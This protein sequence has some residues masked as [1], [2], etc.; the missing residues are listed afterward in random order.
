MIDYLNNIYNNEIPFAKLIKKLGNKI[1]MDDLN[2]YQEFNQMSIKN[3]NIFIDTVNNKNGQ[4]EIIQHGSSIHNNL[5][6]KY[7]EYSR[8]KKEYKRL[9][10]NS[11]Q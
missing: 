4:F 1:T 10:I 11:I 2:I 9:K 6:N 8:L 3:K 5:M 7:F